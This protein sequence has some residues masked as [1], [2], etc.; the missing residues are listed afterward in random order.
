M[1]EQHTQVQA[2]RGVDRRSVVRA[3]VWTVPAVTLATAAPAL[4][5]SVTKGKLKFDNFTVFGADYNSK[6]KPTTIQT[7]LQ[8]QNQYVAGAPTLTTVTVT[9]KYPAGRVTGAAPTHL[10]G[11]GWGFAGASIVSGAW[12]YTFTWSGSLA[13]SHS[14]STLNYR[15]A[16]TD[17]TNETVTLSAIAMATAV[18]SA[19][20]SGSA[21]LS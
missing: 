21:G 19:T 15:V 9:V 1:T 17:T 18:S 8:V 2:R 16:R 7:L 14:T 6:G 11:S 4:A 20:A 3:G 12:V 10:S 5:A 13:P